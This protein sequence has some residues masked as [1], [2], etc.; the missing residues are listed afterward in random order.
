MLFILALSEAQFYSICLCMINNMM[1]NKSNMYVY[2]TCLMSQ[3]YSTDLPLQ[4]QQLW[5]NLSWSLNNRVHSKHQCEGD[6]RLHLWPFNGSRAQWTSWYVRFLFVSY[7]LDMMT[8]A[9]NFLQQCTCFR[10][11]HKSR[12]L[13]PEGSKAN[14]RTCWFKCCIL[15]INK[16]ISNTCLHTSFEDT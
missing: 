12:W 6:T 7:S 11:P 4:H 2:F 3:Y 15:G 5:K 8:L 16:G 13:L 9:I 14:T 10:V 1:L